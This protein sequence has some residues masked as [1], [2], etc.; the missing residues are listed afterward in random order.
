MIKKKK[1]EYAIVKALMG[2]N[3]LTAILLM[4]EYLKLYLRSTLDKEGKNK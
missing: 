2:K 4:T 1:L 3:T